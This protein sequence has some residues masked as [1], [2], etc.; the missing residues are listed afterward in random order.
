MRF[1]I[2]PEILICFIP[3]SFNQPEKKKKA[4]FIELYTPA[5]IKRSPKN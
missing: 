5:R 2:E 3:E 4:N 1:E